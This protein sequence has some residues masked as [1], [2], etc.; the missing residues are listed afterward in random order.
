MNETLKDSEKR[1]SVSKRERER[2]R[3]RV[4]AVEIVSLAVNKGVNERPSERQHNR[5]GHEHD[6]KTRLT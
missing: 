2:E 4:S 5:S 3:Q 6:E 1:E